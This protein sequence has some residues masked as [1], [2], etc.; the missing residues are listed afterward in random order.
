MCA[1]VLRLASAASHVPTPAE[2][3]WLDMATL[4]LLYVTSTGS[5]TAPSCLIMFSLSSAG[6]CAFGTRSAMVSSL[7]GCLF[8]HED[9]ARPAHVTATAA[10]A[11]RASSH[12]IVRVRTARTGARI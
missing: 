7:D 10:A 5:G 8:G 11:G 1:N 3:S 12:G 6:S 9:A 4:G 2:S